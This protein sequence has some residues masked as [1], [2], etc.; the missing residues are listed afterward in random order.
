MLN[1]GTPSARCLLGLAVCTP[2]AQQISCKNKGERILAYL[3]DVTILASPQR[4][5][6]L[7]RRFE[8]HFARLTRLRLNVANGPLE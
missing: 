5:L 1:K 6:H 8:S 4:A 2:G 7:V 3:D